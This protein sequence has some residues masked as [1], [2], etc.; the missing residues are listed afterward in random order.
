MRK[1]NAD[2]GIW[3]TSSCFV[4]T[5]IK[6]PSLHFLNSLKAAIKIKSDHQ[7]FSG[8][9]VRRCPWLNVGLTVLFCYQLISPSR[10]IYGSVNQVSISS[11]NGLS[12][13]RRQAIIWTSAVLLSIEPQGTNCS[14][15][16]TK[17]QNFSFIKM[18][19]NISF[20]K[21]RPFWPGGDEL[22]RIKKFLSSALW[23]P[24]R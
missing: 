7:H 8:F 17:I 12:P 1:E 24:G 14:Q 16:L 21:R 2:L 20:A 3:I 23:N 18:L 5:H 4:V 10:R 15:I 9:Y 19:L 22:P 6:S 11:D 13:I